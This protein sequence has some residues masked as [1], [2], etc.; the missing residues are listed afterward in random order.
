MNP[1]SQTSRELA[2]QLGVE[3]HALSNDGPV[4]RNWCGKRDGD[5]DGIYCEGM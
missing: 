4:D 3:E 2:D 1:S 5:G